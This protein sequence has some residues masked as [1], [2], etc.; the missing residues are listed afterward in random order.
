MS[1]ADLEAKS[2]AI[3]TLDFLSTAPAAVKPEMA[4]TRVGVKAV[5]TPGLLAGL[6][7]LHRKFG[8]RPW[9]ALVEHRPIGNMMRARKVAYFKSTQERSAAPEPEGA[10]PIA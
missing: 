6:D 9:H 5:G 1:C 7:V 10:E 2:G 4:G 3:W 8:V